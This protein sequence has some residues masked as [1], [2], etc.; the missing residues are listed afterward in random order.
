M[1]QGDVRLTNADNKSIKKW[2]GYEPQTEISEGIKKFIKWYR[3][4][5]EV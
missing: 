3:D 4:Y 5:Y 2:I 1:Q